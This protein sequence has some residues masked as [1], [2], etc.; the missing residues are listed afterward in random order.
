MRLDDL[1]K[2]MRDLEEA[3]VSVGVS[4]SAARKATIDAESVAVGDLLETQTD[5]RLL[6]LFE[7]VGCAKL[8][9]RHGVSPRTIYTRREEALGRLQVKK[10]CRSASD[11][12]SQ[13]AA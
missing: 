6:D 13:E 4:R 12:G 5:V 3:L 7:Q 1:S 9:E 10:V 11:A 2:V 8:A